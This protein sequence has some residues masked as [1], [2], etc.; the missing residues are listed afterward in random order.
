VDLDLFKVGGGVVLMI[1]SI[2]LVWGREKQSES[3]DPGDLSIAVVPLAVPMAVGPGT[4]AGL[5]IIGSEGVT[6]PWSYILNTGALLAGILVLAAVLALGVWSNKLLS[7]TTVSV[8][9]RLTGL[10]LSALA[11]KMILEGIRNYLGLVRG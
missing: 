10:F 8:I 7:R 3:A 4:A 1:C 2:T 9:T 6:C 5:I 11:A